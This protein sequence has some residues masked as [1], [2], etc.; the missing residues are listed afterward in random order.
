MKEYAVITGH[1]E[2]PPRWSL[3][4]LQS[5]RT[6]AGPDEILSV[7]RTFREKQLPCDALISL[8][9]GFTKSGWNTYNGEF[10][11]NPATFPDPQKMIGELHALNYK[12]VLHVVLEGRGW[13]AP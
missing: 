1:A 2:M 5:H 7:A 6:L 9:T 8:G 10:A 11:W 12:V 13:L 3:G 4:Y